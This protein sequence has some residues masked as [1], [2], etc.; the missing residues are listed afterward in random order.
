MQSNLVSFIQVLR[1]HDVR[2]SPAETLDA[3]AVASTLGY[4]DRTILRDGLNMALAKTP[5]EA[6]IF[7]QCFDRFFHQELA[8]FSA[9]AKEQAD[10]QTSGDPEQDHFCAGCP[11]TDQPIFAGAS[12][13]ALNAKPARE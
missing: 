13:F 6:V 9:S 12:G 7:E 4:A 5:E 1:T 2:V 11:G 3:M 8:D 10:D